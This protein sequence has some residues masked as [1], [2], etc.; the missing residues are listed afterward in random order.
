MKC[1]MRMRRIAVT[2]GL[3][4]STVF[5]PHYLTKGKIFE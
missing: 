4:R 1:E 2:C 3:P 5:F